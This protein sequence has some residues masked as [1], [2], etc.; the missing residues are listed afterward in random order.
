MHKIDIL[1]NVDIYRRSGVSMR[2]ARYIVQEGL[3]KRL[4]RLFF[5]SFYFW[6]RCQSLDVVQP[7]SGNV[8]W[9]IL[10]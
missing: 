4:S 2:F 9:K 8:A 10:P 7:R 6:D 5:N 3:Y 1:P